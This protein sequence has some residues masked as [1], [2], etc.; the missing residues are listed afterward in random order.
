MGAWSRRDI[1]RLREQMTRQGRDSTEIASEIRVRT[2]VAMLAAY[3]MAAGLS[4]PVLVER[5]CEAAPGAFMDQPLLS[6]LEGFPGPGSRAPLATQIITL[7]SIFEVSPL[8]LLAPDALDQM[9]QHERDVL[10]RCNVT[11]PLRPLTGTA[12]PAAPETSRH[13]PLANPRMERQVQM[14]ARRAMRFGTNA[15][16]GN[17]GPEG[18]DQLRDDVARLA[19]A[20]PQRPLPELLGDLTELQDVTFGLLEG[21]QRPRHTAELYLLAGVLSG[22]L[23]KASHDLGDS[24]SALTQ[25]RTAFICA[26]NIDHAGLK[27]WTAGLRSMI[28]YWA[29]RPNDAVRYAQQGADAAAATHGTASVWLIAQEARGWGLL[30][31][32]DQCRATIQRANEARE[33]VEH[34]ELDE[35]G[36]IMTFPVPR[37]LYYAADASI[38][39]PGAEEDAARQAEAAIG[40]YAE[41]ADLDR[42]FSDEAGARAD[43]AL[44]RAAQS[45]VEG[46]AEA[47]S[48]VLDLPVDQRIEGI[49]TSVRRV[50]RL[51]REPH[52]QGP[53]ARSL[54]Q[55][56]EAYARTPAAAAL[57]TGR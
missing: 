15:E 54:Q 29:S 17:I 12:H 50:H 35:F 49:V 27:A 2:G 33:T 20:Y 21:Q 32:A 28:S 41:A 16:G 52:L 56:I 43:L 4:Q 36:G 31:D 44:A 10:I 42:S 26:D 6:R 23:A 14:A 8:R 19:R 34:D 53:A 48:D 37:Q 45:D 1:G 55:E 25:A 3:R 18:I 51:L 47:L 11:S 40:A 24:H 9:E 57:P 13:W 5:F 39:L 7:A 38:W 30:G 22:I 46:A